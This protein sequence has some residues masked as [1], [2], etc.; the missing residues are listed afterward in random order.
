MAC[1]FL[2]EQEYSI[3]E[4]NYRPKIGDIDIFAEIREHFAFCEVKKVEKQN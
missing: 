2:K 1:V 4:R 3:L